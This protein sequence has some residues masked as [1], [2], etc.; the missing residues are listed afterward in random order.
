M[1]GNDKKLS[2]P[3]PSIILILANGSLPAT[4]PNFLR[5]KFEAPAEENSTLPHILVQ[6]MIPGCYCPAQSKFSGPIKNLPP[7]L[8]LRFL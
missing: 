2:C 6:T 4:D 8:V 5:K 3:L 1:I 7:I